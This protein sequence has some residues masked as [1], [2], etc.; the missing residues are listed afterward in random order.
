M[1]RLTVDILQDQLKYKALL[2]HRGDEAQQILDSLQVVLDSP[3]LRGHDRAIILKALTRLSVKS[4]LYPRCFKLSNVEI[5]GS[6][7]VDEGRYGDVW[8]ATSHSRMVCLK[9][10]RT[11]QRMPDQP[12]LKN[13][14]HE[15]LLWGQ[16]KHPNILPFYGIHIHEVRRSRFGLVSPWM[17]NGNVV[18]YLKQNPHVPRLPLIHDIASGL[19]YL[20]SLNVIHGDIKGN[21]VLVTS[22]GRACLADFG[23][24]SLL[25]DNILVWSSLGSEPGRSGGTTRWRAPE[26]FIQESLGNDSPPTPASDIYSFACAAYEIFTGQIPFYETRGDEAVTLKL[27]NSHQQPSRPAP[28]KMVEEVTDDMWCLLEDCW[29]HE[30]DR[31]PSVVEVLE[32]L[33]DMMTPDQVRFVRSGSSGSVG[34]PEWDA[35][36]SS[37]N[38]RR[39]V[40]PDRKPSDEDLLRVMSMVSCFGPGR[41]AASSINIFP[42]L[43]M[44]H[45]LQT[46]DSKSS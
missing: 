5:L 34:G 16:L 46:E 12:L 39:S 15:A 9:V 26:I 23:L 21:N 40:Q 20:H 7:A 27:I 6:E 8:R 33:E 44:I 11:Y 32:R 13:L 31:R 10:L 24:S 38:F 25:G 30:P 35:M 43:Y 29:N 18:N 14:S 1:H 2:S 4:G 28:D 45:C 22:N 36:L 37:S 42:D 17:E 19:Q 41:E 3:S